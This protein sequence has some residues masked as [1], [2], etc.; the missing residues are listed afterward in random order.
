MRAG[1]PSVN[2][3]ALVADAG[4]FRLRAVGE[5]VPQFGQLHVAVFFHEAGDVVATAP[6][7]GLALDRQGRAA[8]VRERVGVVSH[9]MLPKVA[10]T[11][12]GTC[13]PANPIELSWRGG[14]FD[15]NAGWAKK[16]GRSTSG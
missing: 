3:L 15:L 13:I 11:R 7:A 2:H 6:T 8:E 9:F 12:A 16:P 1:C 10:G 5:H 14:L 4:R